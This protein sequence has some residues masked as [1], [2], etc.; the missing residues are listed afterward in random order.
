VPFSTIRP[1]NANGIGEDK[2]QI[3]RGDPF[4]EW[5]KLELTTTLL[6]DIAGLHFATI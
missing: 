3:D 6:E 4:D 5:R 2:L 1:S